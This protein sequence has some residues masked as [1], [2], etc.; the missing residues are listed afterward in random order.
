MKDIDFLPLKYHETVH[1]RREN[2]KNALLCALLVMA[3][4]GL[5]LMNASRI[6]TTEAALNVLR[7]GDQSRYAEIQR[8]RELQTRRQTLQEQEALLER[9]DD[10]AP[11][12]AV[13]AELTRLMPKGMRVKALSIKVEPV[14]VVDPK[15]APDPVLDRDATRGSLTGLA[16]SDVEVGIFFGKLSASPLFGE[17]SLAFSRD[18]GPQHPG[19][20]EFELGFRVLRVTVSK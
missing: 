15:T 20:R 3:F 18:A 13:L 19:A 1:R 9:L 8:L 4:G 14:Q 16:V 7:A 11:V 2:R 17:V 10:D 5:H 6:R 12:D